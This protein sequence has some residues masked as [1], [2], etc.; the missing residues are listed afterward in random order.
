[1]D[2]GIVNAGMLEVYEAIKPELKEL[3]AK[4]TF[5]DDLIAGR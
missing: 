5:V 1:M 2:M 4:L 3:V